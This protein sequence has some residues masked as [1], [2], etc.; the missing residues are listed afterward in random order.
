[1]SEI[2]NKTPK[3][4]QPLVSVI[5][6]VLNGEKTLERTIKSISSQK[7][8]NIEYIIVDGNSTDKTK[9]IIK[10]YE[11]FISRWISEPDQGLYDAMN[12]GIKL[13]TG[14]Y[15]WFINAGDEI[16]SPNTLEKVF[17]NFPLADIY[18]GETMI[19]DEQG[20]EIGLRRLRPKDKMTWKDFRKGMLI[21][22][23]S[24]IV[25]SEI[26]NKYNQKYRFS[27]DYDWII[28][29]FLKAEKIVN[30]KLILSNFMDGGL[31]KKNI[32][33]SLKERFQIMA[34]VYGFLPSLF[35][36]IPIS[37]NFICFIVKYKR[38]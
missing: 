37:F 12:K 18:Y 35:Y 21:S 25:S 5:T 8:P 3:V 31:T 38:F 26:V 23:Q 20:K 29:V 6:V 1:M 24:V 22:H 15:L 9:T 19:T 13:A 32:R 7:Y 27:A 14:D 28:S 4:K 10:Q 16:A 11:S 17:N 36:H 30:T 34:K 33:E 2:K